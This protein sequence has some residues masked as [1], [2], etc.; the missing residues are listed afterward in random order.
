[1]DTKKPSIIENLTYI[2]EEMNKLF[3]EVISSSGKGKG[4]MKSPTWEPLM[5]IYETEESVKIE[6]E[7]PGI[8]KENIDLE[9]EDYVLTLSGKRKYPESDEGEHFHRIE[10]AYGTFERS[11]SL[12]RSVDTDNIQAEQRCGVLVISIPREK[13]SSGEKIDV[14]VKSKE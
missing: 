10:R 8:E 13:D 2:Q 12:P 1:M 5:D 9:I 6:A 4:K 3:D 14:E 7:L 11:F